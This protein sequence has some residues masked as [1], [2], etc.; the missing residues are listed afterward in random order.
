[1]AVD[2]IGS[3]VDLIG[4]CQG[5]WM[6]L[7]YAARFPAKVRRLVLAGSPID[8]AAEDS[9]ISQL[10]RRTPIAMFTELLKVGEGRLL[11]QMM[12]E[13]W[14][15]AP[16]EPDAIA[17]LLQLERR[18]G[19]TSAGREARLTE[20]FRRWYDWTVDLPGL[21]YLEVV[22]WLYKENR[23]AEGRFSALGRPVDLAAVTLPLLLL[24]GRDDEVTAPAQLLA[25]AGLVGTPPASVVT[26]TAP[27]RHL[28]LFMGAG[29]LTDYWP[30]IV[31][32]LDRAE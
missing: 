16:T 18:P 2:E 15:P 12:L 11:G 27:C 32:W 6:A 8:T 29:T 22:E 17:G 21:Y 1:V 23:L 25:A 28:S 4:L 14:G 20:R 9:A 31:R 24:A 10:A 5:G 19:S 30:E 13:L 7:L 26:M 3:P